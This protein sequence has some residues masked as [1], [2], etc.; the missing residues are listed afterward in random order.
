MELGSTNWSTSTYRKVRTIYKHLRQFEDKTGYR[1][2][3]SSL[4]IT[5]LHKFKAFYE[6]KGNR[7]S[8]TY[9]AVNIIVWFMNWATENGYNVNQEYRKLYKS[10]GQISF[11]PQLH[12]YLR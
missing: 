6:E 8:T 9:K 10:L 3:F 12:L 11:E 7:L 1:L 5:F 2:A 4:N